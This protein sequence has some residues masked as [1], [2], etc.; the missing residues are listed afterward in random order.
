MSGAK[1]IQRTCALRPRVGKDHADRP[2]PSPNPFSKFGLRQNLQVSCQAKC[3]T[4][5]SLPGQLYF[6]RFCLNIF[7]QGCVGLVPRL[8]LSEFG[9]T[10][11]VPV[12]QN[13]GWEW[14]FRVYFFRYCQ[15]LKCQCHDTRCRFGSTKLVSS[16]NSAC[17]YIAEC[18]LLTV[19]HLCRDAFVLAQCACCL[20]KYPA[21]EL[22]SQQAACTEVLSVFVVDQVEMYR[23][24]AGVDRVWVL[25]GG[26][27]LALANPTPLVRLSRFPVQTTYYGHNNYMI[28]RLVSHVAN[29]TN[30]FRFQVTPGEFA[31]RM[32]RDSERERS[33]CVLV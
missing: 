22:L 28:V 24:T 31:S 25:T 13:V 18:F 19:F 6:F 12:R 10:G 3:W 30:G 21:S 11:K 5:F 29:A 8:L 27:T 32:H 20:L 14:A 4:R 7:L 17:V 16:G 2:L 23:G 15:N 1:H 9:K 33:S 26:P